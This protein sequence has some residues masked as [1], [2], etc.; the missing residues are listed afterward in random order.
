MKTSTIIKITIITIIALFTAGTI[1]AYAG[2]R[3]GLAIGA[4]FAKSSQGVASTAQETRE[5]TAA[6][7]TQAKS[8]PGMAAPAWTTTQG[9]RNVTVTS[10]DYR[11]GKPIKGSAKTTAYRICESTTK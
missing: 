11:K 8:K 3:L 1:A 9:C 6:A 10:Q 4:M 2:D 7:A 5:G